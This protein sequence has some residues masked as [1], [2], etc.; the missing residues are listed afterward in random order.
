MYYDKIILV[1]Y[2]AQ[3]EVDLNNR[4]IDL[5]K[6]LREHRKSIGFSQQ[7]MAEHLN[8]SANFYG[9]IERGESK[10]P[11][12]KLIFLCDEYGLDLTYAINGEKSLQGDFYDLLDDC[13]K[14]KLYDMF[15]LIKHASN[16]YREEQHK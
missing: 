7:E 10:I 8:L 16:L 5:G 9:K 13:P 1:I 3:G 4:L 15:E 2:S 12:D 11:I 6:R 14:D